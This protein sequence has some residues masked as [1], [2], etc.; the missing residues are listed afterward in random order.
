M[1]RFVTALAA[2]LV[3]YTLA[4]KPQIEWLPERARGGELARR[5][6]QQ[7][8]SNTLSQEYWL[9]VPLSWSEPKG[10]SFKIRYHIDDSVF[11]A[12]DSRAPIFVSMGGEG[13]S[14]GARC[15]AIAARHK[16]LCVAVE[17]RFYGKSVPTVGGVTTENYKRGL[18]IEMNLADTAAVIDAVQVAHS[19]SSGTRRPVVN[20]GGSYS[21]ATCAWFRQAYPTHTEACV[22]SSGVVNSIVNFPEFDSHVAGALG[23]PHGP[24]CATA[25]HSAMAALDRSFAAGAGDKVKAL[26]NATNLIGTPHGDT[27]FFYAVADGAAM[28]DQYGSKGNLCAGL[29]KLPP[30]PSDMDRLANLAGIIAVHYGRAF[31]SDCFYDSECLKKTTATPGTSLLGGLNSRSWRWQKCSEIAFLQSAPTKGKAMRSAKL[32]I[33][34]LYA[35]CDYVFGE[36]T[37]AAI[38]SRSAKFDAKFGGAK[39][40]SGAFPKTSNI[41]YMD[42]SD[43]PWAEA[44]VKSAQSPSLPYCMT[45]CNGCGHCGAGV[46]SN[47]T[48]CFD[49]SDAF[50]GKV[51]SSDKSVLV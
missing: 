22:S 2:Q 11:N 13:T 30:S 1:I 25:L 32:T 16:A 49:K 19:P 21:G 31:A 46:P 44:S 18:F 39:P 41:F 34:A 10:P 35:Q 51:L 8:E 9:T 15:D 20:F 42:F 45:V 5:F 24:A 17:H 48:E 43:D 3:V 37:S 33:T 7:P 23:R 40:M 28:M 12:T 26:W 14:G 6:L 36:G 27:D 38:A 4:H 29:A 47:L 50:V